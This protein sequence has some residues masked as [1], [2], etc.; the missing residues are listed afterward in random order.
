MPRGKPKGG[1]KGRMK[2]YLTAEEIA[3]QEDR[4]QRELDWKKKKGLISGATPDVPDADNMEDDVDDKLT[5]TSDEIRA[6]DRRKLEE[7]D[8]D[9]DETDSSDDDDDLPKAKGV[10][11]LIE[12][13]NPNRV[14]QKG[15]KVQDVDV[16]V[17]VELSRRERSLICISIFNI[18]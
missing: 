11:G 17:K 15:R 13:E 18:I 3:E 8:D 5:M 2:H 7:N 16:N 4:K 9:S 1:H 12:I 14:K 6:M 10:E